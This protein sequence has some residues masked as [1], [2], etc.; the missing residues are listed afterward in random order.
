MMPGKP[1]RTMHQSNPCVRRRRVSHPSIH[2]PRSV[3][4]PSMKIGGAGLSRFSFG[5]K[6]SSLATST[7]PPRRSEARSTSSVKSIFFGASLCLRA[8]VRSISRQ[9]RKA[10]KDYSTARAQQQRSFG[11]SKIAVIINHLAP[12][13]SLFYHAMKDLAGVRRQLVSMMNQLRFDAQLSITIPN[14]DVDIA[15]NT[16][17]TLSLSQP[18]LSSRVGAQPFT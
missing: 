12:K 7:A 8:F 13:K 4:L 17:Q 3:Y 16:D 18:N 2:L 11:F 9:R 1:S 14:P 6:N 15:A 10:R 5:A